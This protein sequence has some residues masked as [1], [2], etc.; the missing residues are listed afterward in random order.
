MTGAGSVIELGALEK[1]PGKQNW[2]EHL[3]A[4]MRR[5]WNR[6]IVYRAAKHMHFERGMTVGH[7]I[8]SALN[9]ARHICR[10]R[11]VKQWR[12][13]Q[14]V[15]PK[16]W[17]ECC[18]AIAL[19]NTMKAT[20]RAKSASTSIA[21][22]ERHALDLAS[23]TMAGIELIADGLEVI[24]LAKT[25]G[26]PQ[27]TGQTTAGGRSWDEQKHPRAKKGERVGRSKGGQ[28]IRKGAS[29]EQVKA[30]QRELGIKP[31][32]E[33]DER[34]RKAVVAYQRKHGLQVDGIVGAQTAGFMR[35]RPGVKPGRLT[36][37]DKAFLRNR[38]RRKGER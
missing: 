31:T 28:F 3:P 18:A 5:A 14:T 24:E 21:V 15:N 2:I 26:G 36:K 33:F 1:V 17:M 37:S 6:S 10:T 22:S 20:A 9:W 11:D 4:P 27:G 7:A 38:G 34:T 12:G 23:E 19:W 32:G 29:G 25:G 8:A 35:D 13:P 30:I 16:S